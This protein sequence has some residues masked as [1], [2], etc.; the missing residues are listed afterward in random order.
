MPLLE[1]YSP[2]FYHS[3][4][5]K[6]LKRLKL[7]AKEVRGTPDTLD[8]VMVL[9]REQATRHNLDKLFEVIFLFAIS[10]SF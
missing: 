5:F 8:E 10:C 3:V 4:P 7:S 6:L 9:L 1:F 2:N